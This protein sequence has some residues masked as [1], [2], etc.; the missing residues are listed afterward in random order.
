MSRVLVTG[1]SGFIGRHVV[2]GLLERE[3]EVHVASRSDPASSGARWHRVDLMNADQTEAVLAAV[4]PEVL[5]HLAWYTDPRDY[6]SSL[7]NLQ[8]I[9]ASIRLIRL[10]AAHGGERVIGA[11]SCAE[12]DSGHGF[13]SEATTPANPDSLYGAS[14]NAVHRVVSQ[15]ADQLGTDVAWAR[16]FFPYGA[17]EPADKL[18]SY[19]AGRL[20][21][22][23]TADCTSGEQFRDYIHVTDIASF[24][25]ALIESGRTGTFNVGTG[26]PVTV[27]QVVLTIGRILG[28]PD[29]INL[30]ARESPP[31]DVPMLVADIRRARAELAWGPSLSIDTGLELT[32]E[33]IRASGEV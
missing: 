32:I 30:G 16:V 28:A 12:Y 22:G 1:G 5:A 3:H 2:A 29:L 11:G 24:F 33:E 18:V 4:R 27:A 21:R 10:F 25:V 26:V 20:L 9:E 23:L 15:A 7:D 31:G 8:W 19:V 6:R 17:G 13:C 14:K